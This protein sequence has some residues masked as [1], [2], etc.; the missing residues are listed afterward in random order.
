M[1]NYY[2]TTRTNY[3]HVKDEQ[4][5]RDVIA[6]VE[7]D[8]DQLEV[9]KEPDG[10]FGFG[11]YASILGFPVQVEGV[12]EKDAQYCQDYDYEE[13]ANA[14]AECVADD[15]AI[16]ITE[17]GNE[18]MRYV[19][20]HAVVITSKEIRNINLEA[21]AIIAAQDMLNNKKWNTEMHY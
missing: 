17:V 6:K 2:C 9:W 12:S 19:N 13:F 7:C 10:T 4:K 15:D 18:K 1:A 5:F 21:Q 16:I 8:E 14:L 20:G 3:F 11:A